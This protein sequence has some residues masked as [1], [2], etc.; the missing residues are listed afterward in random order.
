MR[1]LFNATCD[2]CNKFKPRCAD[3]HLRVDG[4]ATQYHAGV[5][6]LCHECRQLER[7]R[8]RVSGRHVGK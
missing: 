2:H 4:K 6:T 1:R 7:G 3:V 8:Y 5:T